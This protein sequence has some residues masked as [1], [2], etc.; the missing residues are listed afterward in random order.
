[1]ALIP[2][3]RVIIFSFTSLLSLAVLGICA[4]ILWLTQGYSNSYLAFA[5]FG[6]ATSAVTAVSLPLFL[7]LGRSKTRIFTSAV[8]F[9]IIWFFILWI[10]WVATAGTTVAARAWF[11]PDGC[12]S[13]ATVCYEITAM[14]AF[15]FLNFFAVFIYYDVLFLYAIIC[16]I[17]GRSI[18]TI[19][20]REAANSGVITPAVP[21]NQAQYPQQFTPQYAQYPGAPP[22]VP[23]PGAYPPA[24][25]PQPYYPQ[26]APPPGQPY[27]QQPYPP[28]AGSSPAPQQPAYGA[29]P[30]SFTPQGQP[31][32]LP[33]E[34]QPQPQ[35]GAYQA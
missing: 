21:M 7:I 10:L 8:L 3:L 5:P 14:E 26:Q 4:H 32:P 29:Y 15:A 31:Q 17:R 24:A 20:A 1:M 13:G 12:F 30:G 23:S 16:A 27:P 25:A 19:S 22:P 11:F 33:A 6:T 28:S 9:E 18:W 35:Y 34:Y 2:L